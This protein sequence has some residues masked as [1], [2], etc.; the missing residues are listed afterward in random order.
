MIGFYGTQL[1]DDVRTF[2]EKENI[3]FVILF[4][5]NIE[6]IPQVKELT[7]V[8]HGLGKFPPLIYTDQE[9]GTI[10]R[11][12]E[13]AATAISAMGIAAT[14][15]YGNAEIAGR[16]IA[17][18][19]KAC[20]IDGVFAPVLDV[21]T[22]E[23]NPVIGVR[24]FSDRPETVVVYAEHFYRGL[25]S[26]GVLTCGKHYP[27]HGAASADSHLEIPLINVSRQFFLDYCYQPF[28][29]LAGKGIDAMMTAHVRFPRL[30]EDIA[31]FS[32]Y[33]VQ[34]LLRNDAGF[35]GV[36]FSD[37]LEMKAVKDNFTAD[38]IVRNAVNAGIDVLI[39][40]HTLQF[41]QELLDRLEFNVKQGTITEAR[42]D[43]SLARIK[44]LKHQA[45][46]TRHR[47][48]ET[49]LAPAQELRQNIDREREIAAQ[50][51]TLLRHQQGLLPLKRDAK[52]LLIEWEKKIIGPSVSE[53][54]GRSMVEMV[55]NGFL[56]QRVYVMLKPDETDMLPED[57]ETRLQA[58]EDD[59]VIAC[60]YSRTGT[61]SRNQ[62]KAVKRLLHLRS[63]A[64][65]VSMEN[66]YEIKKFPSARTFLVTY[67]F[68]MVQVEA[69]F[70]VLTGQVAPA[71]KLPVEIKGLFPRGSG[72]L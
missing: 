22:E 17:E 42:I 4:S 1:P 60:I 51:I 20:G 10:V 45:A 16:I 53:D 61:A 38:E 67:G 25:K 12:G 2:I 55:S 39:P 7:P 56:K 26:G 36:V 3:G 34:E 47:I 64:V 50:S 11:F 58:K 30:T 21:N 72:Q 41:Q 31:T 35:N 68:R 62:F 59:V 28:K 14:G 52:I 66:P 69:L 63:D 32:P 65:I 15:S 18:D 23:D 44:A 27:G 6:S 57:L 24:S 46:L 19:M 70:K 9:G 43:E 29:R 33:L 40:S 54:E 37:C 48:S 5:R 13:M 49:A 8:L 71:G